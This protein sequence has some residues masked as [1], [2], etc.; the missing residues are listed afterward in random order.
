MDIDY[1]QNSNKNNERK[2]IASTI[3]KVSP[4]SKMGEGRESSKIRDA[5]SAGGCAGSPATG[6]SWVLKWKTPI[7]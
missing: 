2:N 3:S 5:G 1:P 6:C 7:R 4:G